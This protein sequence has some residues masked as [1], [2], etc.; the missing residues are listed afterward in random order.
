MKAPELLRN[1]YAPGLEAGTVRAAESEGLPATQISVKNT[2]Y[3]NLRPWQKGQSG[4]PS[5]RPK[6]K[7]VT[8]AIEALADEKL[9]AK[10]LRG[11]RALGFRGDTWAQAWAFG[12]GVKAAQ[13]D[14]S[15]LREITDRIEGKVPAAIVGAGGGFLLPSRESLNEELERILAEVRERHSQEQGNSAPAK[16]R[17]K[18]QSVPILRPQNSGW[19]WEVASSSPP[20]LIAAGYAPARADAV[21]EF[22]HEFQGS[23]LV[24]GAWWRN[25]LVPVPRP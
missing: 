2:E 23:G 19:T 4:N 25:G 16:I 18:S 5:G 9:P 3:P 13:G 17:R 1:S 11:L 20:A 8:E 21:M 12:A 6:K 24:T 14:T 22:F 15:A 7:P 10:M